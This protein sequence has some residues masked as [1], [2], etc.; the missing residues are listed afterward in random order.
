MLLLVVSFTFVVHKV[1]IISYKLRLLVLVL[2][3]FDV[4]TTHTITRKKADDTVIR[5]EDTDNR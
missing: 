2:H 4:H 5:I 3:F 1:I